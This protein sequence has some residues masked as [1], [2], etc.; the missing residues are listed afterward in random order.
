MAQVKSHTKTSSL[1]REQA[2]R[3]KRLKNKQAIEV[4]RLVRLKIEAKKEE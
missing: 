1:P 3:L 2:P 4:E